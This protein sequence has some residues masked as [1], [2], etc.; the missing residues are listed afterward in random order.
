MHY[1]GNNDIKTKGSCFKMEKN[2]PETANNSEIQNERAKALIRTGDAA[3]VIR[4]MVKKP[5]GL[6]D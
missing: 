2:P 4:G 5:L 3:T 1:E 6:Q